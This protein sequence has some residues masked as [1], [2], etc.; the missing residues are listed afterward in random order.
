MTQGRLG[1]PDAVGPEGLSPDVDGRIGSVVFTFLVSFGVVAATIAAVLYVALNGPD[2]PATVPR[3]TARAKPRKPAKPSKRDR[4]A[5]A[6][7]AAAAVAEPAPR[8]A[9]RPSPGPPVAQVGIPAGPALALPDSDAM[10]L[11][12]L[13]AAPT[14]LWVRIRSGVALVVL[15]GVLGALLALA[16]GGVL[17]GAALL[18]RSATG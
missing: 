7:A 17:V 4:R 9:A 10:R 14:T 6:A 11:R 13:P 18:I 15:V 12:V 3:A 16:V 2:Q 8:R 5:A 1:R